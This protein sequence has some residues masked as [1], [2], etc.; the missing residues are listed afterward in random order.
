MPF[1]II[2]TLLIAA[3]FWVDHPKIYRTLYVVLSVAVLTL[4]YNTFIIYTA[5][6][7]LS[8]W[9]NSGKV[10]YLVVVIEALWLLVT[11]AVMALLSRKMYIPANQLL[12]PFLSALVLA[13]YL[14]FYANPPLWLCICGAIISAILFILTI[15]LFFINFDKTFRLK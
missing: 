7:E 5:D 15:V 3:I 10:A 2:Y 12:L 6:F 1:V 14:I 11:N 4:I 8:P 9:H 13:A